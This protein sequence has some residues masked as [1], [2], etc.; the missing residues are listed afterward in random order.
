MQTVKQAIL[1]PAL[2][3]VQQET[4]MSQAEDGDY[5]AAFN[6][7]IE[8]YEFWQA[9]GIFL[10]S[11]PPP[12]MNAGVSTE[13]PTYTMWTN[14]V[15]HLSSYFAYQPTMKQSADAA[16]SFRVLRNR[17][18]GKALMNCP[19]N[20][21]RGTGNTYWRDWVCFDDCENLE[22]DQDANLIAGV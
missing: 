6:A 22:N 18:K 11:S 19:N 21:P 17:Q 3:A 1:K 8:M 4:G 15:L 12:N 5:E 2:R 7:L 16:Q 9:R 20:M 14:L 10:W 13:D